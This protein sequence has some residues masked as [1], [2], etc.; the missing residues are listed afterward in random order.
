MRGELDEPAAGGDG[1]RESG[2]LGKGKE[3]D[4]AHSVSGR[5]LVETTGVGGSGASPMGTSSAKSSSTSGSGLKISYGEI[6]R[7]AFKN[8]GEVKLRRGDPGRK[9]R[10]DKDSGEPNWLHGE[11]GGV[12]AGSERLLR[13]E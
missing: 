13:G 1:E 9:Q 3:V 11:S 2:G 6:V 4:A 5:G 12:V 7:C 8:N 10:E